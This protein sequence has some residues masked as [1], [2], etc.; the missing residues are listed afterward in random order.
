MSKCLY[1]RMSKSLYPNELN[2]CIKMN[3]CL[4]PNE[5]YM[6]ISERVKVCIWISRTAWYTLFAHAR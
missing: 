6:S 5:L 4:Y 3:K 2:V 1:V